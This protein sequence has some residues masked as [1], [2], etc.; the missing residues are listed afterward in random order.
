MLK[1]YKY[2]I[3]SIVVILFSIM[4]ANAV[5]AEELFRCPVVGEYIITNGPGE[6]M[7]TGISEYA[8]DISTTGKAVDVYAVGDGK[9][10]TAG[11]MVIKKEGE[12]KDKVMMLPYGSNLEGYKIVGFG[13]YIVINHNNGYESLYAHLSKID[14]RQ[15]DNV[16]KG[17]KIAKSGNTGLSLGQTG[18][19]L[20]FEIRKD[21]RSVNLI[22]LMENFSIDNFNEVY[23]NWRDGKT[24]ADGKPYQPPGANQCSGRIIGS[25]VEASA[26]I[27]SIAQE[28]KEET[29]TFLGNLINVFKII[30]KFFANVF[31]YKST[32]Y[33]RAAEKEEKIVEDSY[34]LI[35][36]EING[37]DEL[38]EPVESENVKEKSQVT[39]ETDEKIH[40]KILFYNYDNDNNIEDLYIMNLDGSN[41]IKLT[42]NTKDI[43]INGF[44]YLAKNNIII[45]ATTQQADINNYE[46]HFDCLKMIKIDENTNDIK[47]TKTILTNENEN[48]FEYYNTPVFISNPKFNNDGDELLF[49]CSTYGHGGGGDSDLFLLSLADGNITNLTNN[50]EGNVVYSFSNDNKKVVYVGSWGKIFI[51]DLENRNRIKLSNTNGWCDEPIFSPDDKNI[52]FRSGSDWDDGPPG[53]GD[54]FIVDSDG[55]NQTNITNDNANNGEAIY[56]FNESKIIFSS[57]RDYQIIDE[58]WSGYDLYILGLD[59]K[60]VTRITKDS[61]FEWPLAISKD[62][63]YLYFMKYLKYNEPFELH[64]YNLED[65]EDLFLFKTSGMD[66]KIYLD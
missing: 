13:H 17:E 27:E 19:H 21:G 56:L 25:P 30:G 26:S 53:Y 36:L 7:H 66:L 55:R 48:F 47:Y 8:I 40:C 59:T 50:K 49:H 16:V 11:T 1:F 54:L 61:A 18:F 32:Y 9:V 4:P 64:K 23:L 46:S 15:G 63:K 31:S 10:K 57:S 51:L 12:D 35:D 60:L 3:L 5:Y 43:Y 24:D 39:T 34:Q 29:H 38:N 20:H 52:I 6:G 2:I 65:G 28:S 62:D 14:V 22:G 42:N 58:N 44:D 41:L 37:T 33:V 45:F